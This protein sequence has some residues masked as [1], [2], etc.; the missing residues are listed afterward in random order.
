M[1]FPL[2]F[3]GGFSFFLLN[4]KKGISKVA[5]KYSKGFHSK[6]QTEGAVISGTISQK[7][8]KIKLNVAIAQTS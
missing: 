6:C 2:Q 8:K 1:K 7:K 4:C 3:V 5:G